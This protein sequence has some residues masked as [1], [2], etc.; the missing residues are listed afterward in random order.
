M[1]SKLKQM[2]FF[3]PL[4]LAT[5]VYADEPVE[6]V[7]HKFQKSDYHW[8]LDSGPSQVLSLFEGLSQ[9]PFMRFD[10]GRCVFCTGQD[11]NCEYDGIVEIDTVSEPAEPVLAVMCH[12][13]A[14]SQ[15]LQIVAP[16]RNNSDAVFSITGA[17]Y[18]TYQQTP[19]GIVAQYDAQSDDG[20]FKEVVAHWP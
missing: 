14:H 11:D 10:L 17:Y 13:G 19:Q 20:T 1:I 5:F 16:Q 12:V 8:Q 7:R 18:A 9:Q 4:V 6:G 15:R 3:L 2:I